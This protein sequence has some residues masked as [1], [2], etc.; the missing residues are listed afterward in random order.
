LYDYLQL[1]NKNSMIP[2]IPLSQFPIN[3]VK[4][5]DIENAYNW[6]K[7]F[8]SDKDWLKRK[9]EIENYLSN[10][11]RSSEPFSE[12]ISEGTLLVVKKDQIG[13]YL[14]LVHVYLFEPH[15]YEYFQGARV[16]PI[17]KR[18]GMDVNLVVKIEGINKKMREMFKK[19]TSEADAILFE[20]LTS[21]LWVRNGWEVKII[22][23]GK[24]PKTPDFEVVKGTE[25]W[26]VECKR[27]MKT[28]DYTYK[29]TKKRQIMI[30]QISKLLLQFNIL[31]DIKFHVELVSLPDSYLFDLLNDIISTTK[32][33]CKIIS[34]ESVDIELSFV[35][36]E[37]I[38]NHLKQYLVKNNS[39]QL[40]ELIAKKEVDHSAF[41]SGFLGTF[42]YVGDG[43]ANNLYINEIAKAFGVHCYCDSENALNAKARDVRRQIKSAISQFNP[44]A[45]SI[46]HIGMETFDGPEVEMARTE[47]LINTMSNIDP[48]SNKLGWIFYHYFQSYTR[49]Y[50][51]W[52]FDETV[53]TAT[54]FINPVLPIKNTF[55]IIPEDEVMIEDASHWDKELP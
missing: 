46:I 38:Q 53:S 3:P 36:I 26:Q 23:E 24:G 1:K 30:S 12:P 55:L 14:Y 17:F 50:M 13:W 52:Y 43:E 10:I 27:Q 25:K 31:L 6:F 54:S 34:N 20:V 4:D 32:I 33:P 7:S 41:T 2:T 49:S 37:L 9:N 16:I 19:R 8:I 11:V 47:K 29:E 40:F 5:I 21:L 15:K 44:E 45:N 18:I 22:E 39:P 51:D 42:Y 35:D 28:A 48:K